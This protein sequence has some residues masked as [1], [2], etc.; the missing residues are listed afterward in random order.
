MG[1]HTVMIIESVAPSEPKSLFE[2]GRGSTIAYVARLRSS[3]AIDRLRTRAQCRHRYACPRCSPLSFP[4]VDALLRPGVGGS[5]TGQL[6]QTFQDPTPDFVFRRPPPFGG[7]R[8]TKSGVAR[9]SLSR[10]SLKVVLPPTRGR[11]RAKRGI[12]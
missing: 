12:N 3:R 2:H 10:L 4:V 6:K 8:K 11:R 1:T 7:R 5:T 9:L